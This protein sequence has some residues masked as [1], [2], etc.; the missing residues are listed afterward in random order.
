MQ[1]HLLASKKGRSA[2]R[3]LG[4]SPAGPQSAQ[5]GDVRWLKII[6]ERVPRGEIEEPGA[7]VHGIAWGRRD[8]GQPT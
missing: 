6:V 4:V 1:G 8:G 5:D 2:Y 7:V 3:I